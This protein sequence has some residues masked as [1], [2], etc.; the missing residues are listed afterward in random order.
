M[1]TTQQTFFI[2]EFL[3]HFTLFIIYI[4]I[5]V[6]DMSEGKKID[7]ESLLKYD[8]IIQV[9]VVFSFLLPHII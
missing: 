4:V 7:I 6:M 9:P 5:R 1:S 2:L 8:I 3:I